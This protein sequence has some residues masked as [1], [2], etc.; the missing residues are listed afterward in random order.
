M[1]K[2]A[3]ASGEDR[4]LKG[5][6]AFLDIDDAT[7]R[8]LVRIRPLL[9]RE[10]PRGLDRFYEKVKATPQTAAFFSGAT[11]MDRAKRSQVSHWNAIAQG[12]FDERYAE[13]VNRIGTVHA[14][15]GLCPRWYIGGYAL[16]SIEGTRAFVA[17]KFL[18]ALQ[19]NN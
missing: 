1:N 10:I 19:K 11:Q 4:D 12:R 16:E 7:C 18:K 14:D 15:I 9:E 8:D 17:E 5:R 6:M 3:E 13:Q 2:T